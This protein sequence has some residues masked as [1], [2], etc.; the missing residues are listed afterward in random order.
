MNITH[1]PTPEELGYNIDRLPKGEDFPK[2]I[3]SL[4]A[5]IIEYSR[6]IDQLLPQEINTECGGENESLD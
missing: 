1:L 5:S 6:Q 2:A 3:K 4:A